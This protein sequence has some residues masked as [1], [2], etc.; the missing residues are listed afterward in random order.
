[1][2]SLVSRGY[3]SGL[4]KVDGPSYRQQYRTCK[5]RAQQETEATPVTRRKL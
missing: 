2:D 3:A 1:M 5:E 4:I